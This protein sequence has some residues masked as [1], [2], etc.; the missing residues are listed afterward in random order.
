MAELR[1]LLS[2]LGCE[3]VRTYLQSG[4][5]LCTSPVTDPAK[6][7]AE[8][9]RAIKANFGMSVR[10]LVRTKE[11]LQAVIDGHPLRDVATD[12][13]KML[14]LF[15]S[16]TLDPALVAANNPQDLA[17]D[18]VYLGDRVIYQWCPDGILQAPPISAFVERHLKLSVTARNWNTVT[19]MAAL[20]AE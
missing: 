15:L 8:V 18:Q 9:E 12:G 11:E 5:A 17:P 1:A 4:N 20:M 7:G 6:L 3:E 13:A 14:A 2:Q 10:C 16:D 19:K